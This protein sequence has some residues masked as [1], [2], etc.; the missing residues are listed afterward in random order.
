MPR[1]EDKL[2]DEIRAAVKISEL[3]GRK[4]KLIRKGPG[5]FV[6][7][8]PF[9]PDSSPDS[10]TCN[11]GK[12]F[13]HDFATSEHGDIFE[14]IQ[15]SEGLD[16]PRSVEVCARVAG[17]SLD[18]IHPKTA[19]D[20]EPPD[21]ATD[22]A[23]QSERHRSSDQNP[24]KHIAK[25]YDYTDSQGELIYQVVR[26]E[27]KD[28][29]QRR[30]DGKGGWVWNLQG[31]AH[32]FY[33]MQELQA[34]LDL[35]PDERPTIHLT[36]GEKDADLLASWGFVATTNSG[37]A[38]HW[39]EKHAALLAGSDVVLHQDNDKAGRE[40]VEK[41]APTLRK[42]GARVRVCDLS[43]I[44]KEM[45]EK[46]DVSDWAQSGG[47]QEKLYGILEELKD[48]TPAPRVSKFG[49]IDWADQDQPGL[50]EY[51]WW[52]KGVVPKRESI[53]V[54]GATQTG[55]SFESFN[56]CMHI[57]QGID[58]RGARTKQGLVVYCA[59]E[60]GKGFRDRMRGYRQHHGLPLK[61]I[62]MVVLTRRFD[63]F[64]NENDLKELIA[65]IAAIK[66]EWPKHELALVAIDTYSAV[67]PGLKENTSEDISRVRQR[68]AQ[69]ERELGCGTLFVD[70]T[71]AVGDKVRGHTSKTADIETQL[72][73]EWVMRRDG[74]DLVHVE[75]E[76]R[77]RVR[78]L[79]IFKQR[80]GESGK[81]WDFVLKRIDVRKDADGDWITTCVSIDPRREAQQ[82][83][84]Q[85]NNRQR[86]AG[87]GFWLRTD[88]QLNLFKAMLR[89]LDEKGVPPLASL[90]LPPS[91][92]KVVKWFDVAAEYRRLVPIEDNEKPETYRDKIKK[93]LRDAREL[94]IRF[95]VLGVDEIKAA[96]G[97]Q[98]Y[99]VV[100]PTG[101]RVSGQGFEWPGKPVVVSQINNDQ[102]EEA[103]PDGDQLF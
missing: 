45:P 76:D 22:E 44:W 64:S 32:G 57:A 95:A 60:G 78:R 2:L 90:N 75:D 62:P 33:R 82:E 89:A 4:T 80:E 71:N 97:G 16:F 42:S 19:R 7:L 83:P 77:R 30:P 26:Y 101:K 98:G 93:R 70:H 88:N 63:L 74:K 85:K 11:D 41:I 46:S 27:P 52:V 29:R 21:W 34:M 23:A 84:E 55:K 39:N 61:D 40:R 20:D 31:V 8:S 6:G 53:A 38:K 3:V 81:H 67:T 9:R 47:T 35:K 94:M 5:E 96:D 68:I 86:A 51:E 91:V 59:P 87:G 103:P 102:L 24:R 25:T 99:H 66:T 92:T 14:F 17:I 1:F 79:T 18:G 72:N 12:G 28:F 10:F 73:V 13:Y 58:Y 69:L 37:G 54:V 15:K 65:E 50:T 100:W 43:A 56:L 36:E 49:R 48:W